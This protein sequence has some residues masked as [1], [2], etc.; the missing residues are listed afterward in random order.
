[1]TTESFQD[2]AKAVIVQTEGRR[3]SLEQKILRIIRRYRAAEKQRARRQA[4]SAKRTPRDSPRHRVH[5]K[6]H[7]AFM[8]FPVFGKAAR[9]CNVS[10]PAWTASA[11]LTPSARG[12]VASRLLST[13]P[14]DGWSG[15]CLLGSPI[16]AMTLGT[17][18]TRCRGFRKTVTTPVSRE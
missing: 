1:M 9:I 2:P 10:T 5:Q 18:R 16:R 14:A 12:F 6:H 8:P 13:Y 17:A 11:A 4:L 7:S 15:I 3:L